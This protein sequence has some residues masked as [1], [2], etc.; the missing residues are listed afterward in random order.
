M[1]KVV[2]N[3]CCVVYYLLCFLYV[4]FHEIKTPVYTLNIILGNKV[5]QI[6]PGTTLFRLVLLYI[7]KSFI[8]KRNPN[9]CPG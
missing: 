1:V 3:T 8:V 2:G 7:L 4:P 9:T 6:L 5:A